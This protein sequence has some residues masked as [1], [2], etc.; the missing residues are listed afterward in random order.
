[1]HRIGQRIICERQLY[2]AHSKASL[3]ASA[4]VPYTN[5]MQCDDQP[6]CSNRN[7]SDFCDHVR[8][9]LHD[10]NIEK[11]E[12][13]ASEV[14]GSSTIRE[15]METRPLET[16]LACARN[17]DQDHSHVHTSPR[18]PC[19]L[20]K[21]RCTHE[22]QERQIFKRAFHYPLPNFADAF[23]K[24]TAENVPLFDSG[25]FEFPPNLYSSPNTDSYRCDTPY[26]STSFDHVDALLV[27]R[28]EDMTLE[29]ADA[30]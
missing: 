27:R 2:D 16:D 18:L 21:L 11:L 23:P 13:I 25:C 30:V 10:R 7:T 29:K 22:K 26:Q 6:K 3:P 12:N 9:Y 8:S 17:R 20:S 28:F 14:D 24:R 19:Y 4:C 1:M 15:Y 5:M